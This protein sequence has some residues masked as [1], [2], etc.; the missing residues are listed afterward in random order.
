MNAADKA[1]AN[2][3][4]VDDCL[5]RAKFYYVDTEKLYCPEHW[6]N[7]LRIEK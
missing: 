7:L 2:L 6:D 4:H 3:C 1:A 5:Q